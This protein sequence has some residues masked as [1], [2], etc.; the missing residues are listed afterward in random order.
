MDEGHTPYRMMAPGAEPARRSYELPGRAAELPRVDDYRDDIDFESE[1]MIGGVV[2][3]VMGADYPHAQR[4]AHLDYLLR[5]LAAPG[6]TVA[7]DLKT[8]VSGDD[9]FASDSAL[10]REGTDPETET[11]YLEE[12]AFEVVDKQDPKIITEKV[13]RMIRRGVRRVFAVFVKTGRVKEWATETEEWVT[14][15]PSALIEDP[16]LVEPVTVKALLDAAEADD[17]VVRGLAKKDNP[18]LQRIRRQ[19]RIEGQIEGQA[20]GKAEG[21][22]EAQR[23]AVLNVLAARGLEVPESVRET[24]LSCDDSTVLDRWVRAAATADAADAVLRA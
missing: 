20:E 19:E 5:G 6:Y 21:R 7:S 8:R 10:V 15:H 24:V 11:R 12:I 1:E 9:D 17:A 16:T 22:L 2:Y 4:N 14:L 13:P 23:Q 18:E 3:K